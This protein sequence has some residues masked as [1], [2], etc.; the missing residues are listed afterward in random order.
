MGV[1]H[2]ALGVALAAPPLYRFH[3][4]AVLVVRDV[5]ACVCALMCVWVCGCV[6]V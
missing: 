5:C 1:L 3:V 6:G 4:Q 2:L